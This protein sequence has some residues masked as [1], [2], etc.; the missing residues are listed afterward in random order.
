MAVGFSSV[1][2][3]ERLHEKHSVL[4]AFF[5][6]LGG[7]VLEYLCGTEE[8]VENC[9]DGL[10]QVRVSEC[11][12]NTIIT[13]GLFHLMACKFVEALQLILPE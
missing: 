3:E 2:D 1:L 11:S 7:R 6:V 4:S 10:Q 12:P 5:A 9:G 8:A 13:L